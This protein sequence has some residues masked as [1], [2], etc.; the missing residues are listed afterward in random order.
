MDGRAAA[1]CLNLADNA[2]RAVCVWKRAAYI[3]RVYYRHVYKK[4]TVLDKI[5]ID[6]LI[7]GLSVFVMVIGGTMVSANAVGQVSPA[8]NIPMQFYYMGV[9]VCGILMVIYAAERLIRLTR[10]YAEIKKEGK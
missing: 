8:M 6:M 2:G 3:D 4:G 5:F 7:L 9:P 1:V 10:E